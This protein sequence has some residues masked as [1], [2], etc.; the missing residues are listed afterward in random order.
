MATGTSLITDALQDGG[1]ENPTTNQLAKGLRRFNNLLDLWSARSLLVP[2]NEIEEFSLIASQAVYTIGSGGDFNTT[3]PIKIDY[4]GVVDTNSQYH[5]LKVI[6]ERGYEQIWNKDIS[7]R[8]YEIYL[9]TEFPLAVIKLFPT[10]VVIET[11]RISSQKPLTK[12]S[13]IEDAINLPGEYTLALQHRLTR[14]LAPSFGWILDANFIDLANKSE[15][16]IISLRA[17]RVPEVQYDPM[18]TYN[19]Q[20]DTY[21]IRRG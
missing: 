1:I 2:V 9:A 7:A 17:S 14:L 8:P 18:L 10:P 20:L 16:V 19:R 6:E 3:R 4:A 11:L 15:G 12:L 5:S 13:S 21:D